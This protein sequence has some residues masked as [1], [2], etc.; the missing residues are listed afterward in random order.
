MPRQLPRTHRDRYVEKRRSEPQLA[1]LWA[2]CTF[3][4]SVLIRSFGHPQCCLTDEHLVVLV[5]AVG[6]FPVGVVAKA[7][8]YPPSLQ[9]VCDSQ[10][11]KLLLSLA[12]NRTNRQG[13]YILVLLQCDA[14]GGRHLWAQDAVSWGLKTNDS[15]IVHDIVTNLGLRVDRRDLPAKLIVPVGI[16]RERCILSNVDSANVGFVDIGPNFQA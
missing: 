13:E 11:Y 16:D 2:V 6:N 8:C 7:C 10:H 1:H 9:T 3:C 12:V 14:N 15:D 5:K 4:L